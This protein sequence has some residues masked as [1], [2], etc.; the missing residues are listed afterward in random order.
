[1]KHLALVLS[2]TDQ[3]VP[4]YQE[5]LERAVREALALDPEGTRCLEFFPTLGRWD[6]LCFC[7]FKGDR[8]SAD[9]LNFVESFPSLKKMDVQYA[10]A[11]DEHLAK[12]EEVL[13]GKK[14]PL[15]LLSYFRL[16]DELALAHGADA[17]DQV[18]DRL[19][20][21]GK[22]GRLLVA[23]PQGWADFAFLLWGKNIEKML[24]T[25]ERAW[26]LAVGDLEHTSDREA[27]WLLEKMRADQPAFSRSFSVV[28]FRQGR[29]GEV[30]GKLYSPSVHL[31]TRPGS[32]KRIEGLVQGLK[33]RDRAAKDAKAE[34]KKETVSQL[35]MDDAVIR[36]AEQDDG[37]TSRMEAGEL[38][39]W[40]IDKLL[41]KLSR[42]IHA[43]ELRLGMEPVAE[44]G[45]IGDPPRVKQVQFPPELIEQLRKASATRP[46]AGAL[47]SI[48]RMVNWGMDH[49]ALYRSVADLYLHTYALAQKIK[50]RRRGAK[51]EAEFSPNER[52]RLTELTSLFSEA[53]VQRLQGS[54]YD[55]MSDSPE[56]VLELS[57]NMS[58]TVLS[59]WAIQDVLLRALS[60]ATKSQPRAYWLVS[61]EGDP[62]VCNPF[63]DIFVFRISSSLLFDLREGLYAIGHEIG[64]AAFILQR[65]LADD[66]IEDARR[67]GTP[68]NLASWMRTLSEM[69]P[70]PYGALVQHLYGELY[71]DAFS[72]L[73]LLDGDVGSV[74][75]G[76]DDLAE[77]SVEADPEDP[78][79]VYEIGL[80]MMFSTWMARALDSGESVI[81]LFARY[82][83]NQAPA[84]PKPTTASEVIDRVKEALD[85]C[86]D[87]YGPQAYDLA[88]RASL[89][90]LRS[91]FLTPERFRDY[92]SLFKSAGALPLF[93]RLGLVPPKN[94]EELSRMREQLRRLRKPDAAAD[95]VMA[96]VE[97][98]DQALG[99]LARQL[100]PLKRRG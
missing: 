85:A 28:A 32:D 56:V 15:L 38:L 10:T 47:R 30:D 39:P 51:G 90:L 52:A 36:F 76:L 49:D 48:S 78:M 37:L 100:K 21:L 46:L 54:Y 97:L 63:E 67:R 7:S 98:Y 74:Q 8:L 62:G 41:P 17:L 82:A 29:L 80:R 72:C 11:E 75:Q 93:L 66:K 88:Q 70:S 9:W 40:Y 91:N 6:C 42:L 23:W 73:F 20:E 89:L 57:G 59:L 53:I 31:R 12:F 83:R 79:G 34:P 24:S 81:D 55:M 44:A 84:L 99:L 92:D 96:R 26:T 65:Q 95:K 27:R 94:K 64:H 69:E 60:T 77:A 19:R 33:L 18:Q 87:V 86:R 13:E 2:R 1:M 50:E 14:Y 35:G 45:R 4:R 25:A 43:S 58:R 5:Y 68:A 3:S 22:R 71:A 61:K 16:R